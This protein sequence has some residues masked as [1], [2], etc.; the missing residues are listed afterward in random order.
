[1]TITENLL[2]NMNLPKLKNGWVYLVGAGPG[3]PAL[4]TISALS[5]ITQA[6]AI[7]Y[8]ALVNK[9]ILRNANKKCKLIFAG[10]R[11]GRKSHC[12]QDISRTIVKLANEKLKV[13]RLK[14]GDPFI[15]ARGAEEAIELIKNN[16]PFCVIPGITAAIAAMGLNKIPATHRHTNHSAR[17]ITG[18]KN[19]QFLNS[20]KVESNTSETL[21]F[22]MGLKNIQNIQK[23]LLKNGM[24]KKTPCAIISNVSLKTMRCERT[25]LENL[26]KLGKTF[27]A[28]AIIIIAK[29]L[30]AI[31]D[32][33]GT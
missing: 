28:P 26:S 24:C 25:V 3:D 32:E 33:I 15:F 11:G 7:V 20:L 19:S 13:L 16:I 5:A 27:K 10:K 22:Y 29:T 18:H 6:D 4:L 1:M 2:K 9:D 8:D 12:Q 17:F 21:V 23:Q 30:N 31:N 14:G